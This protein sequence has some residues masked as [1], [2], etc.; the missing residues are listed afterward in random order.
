MKNNYK[1]PNENFNYW[2]LWFY[3]LP[4]SYNTSQNKKYKIYG[5]DNINDY[6]DLNLKKSSKKS[7]I[8]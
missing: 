8:S 1:R 7:E 3:W 6:Y 5:I 4:P 2:M